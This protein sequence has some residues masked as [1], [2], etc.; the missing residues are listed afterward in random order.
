MGLRPQDSF[1]PGI[2]ASIA[3]FFETSLPPASPYSST[4]FLHKF[5]EMLLWNASHVLWNILIGVKIGHDV[6]M[7]L[8][9]SVFFIKCLVFFV[10]SL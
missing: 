3:K 1:V 2:L 8:F 7:L 6:E 9:F 5:M 10:S 4:V